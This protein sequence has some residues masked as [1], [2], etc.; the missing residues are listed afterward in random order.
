MFE[1]IKKIKSEMASKI[2]KWKISNQ[3]RW[4]DKWE[5]PVNRPSN[6]EK[7][8]LREK[9]NKRKARENSL[10]YQRKKQKIYI[11]LICL[12]WFMFN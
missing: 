3:N 8:K 12:I 9:F 7:I 4:K 10:Q 5:W 11:F 1:K 2:K 6:Q